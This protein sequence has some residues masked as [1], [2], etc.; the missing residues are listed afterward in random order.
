V[1]DDRAAPAAVQA[2]Q[3]HQVDGGEREARDVVEVGAVGGVEPEPGHRL[4]EQVRVDAV[5]A[6]AAVLVGLDLDH[7]GLRRAA[8]PR[9]RPRVR[10]G[11]LELVGGAVDDELEQ[12]RARALALE[13]LGERRRVVLG[14]DGAQRDVHLLGRHVALGR[15]DRLDQPGL[16]VRLEAS[17]E[18]QQRRLPLPLLGDAVEA[19]VVQLVTEV[20]RE[21]EVLVGQR[22]GGH[23]RLGRVHCVR[24]A[25]ERV[26]ERVG[27]RAARDR[28]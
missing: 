21:L 26:E 15:A 9:E 28:E 2:E 8:Q 14:L 24:I 23:R 20:E 16:E 6:A 25:H 19:A 17:A 5:G 11:L 22:I 18:R 12:L 3:R 4:G 27:Q 7:R 13:V 1:A 10:V